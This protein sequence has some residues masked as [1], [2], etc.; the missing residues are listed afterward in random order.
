[1]LLPAGDQEEEGEDDEEREAADRR[2]DDDKHLPLVGRQIWR[3]RWGRV[4]TDRQGDDGKRG[5]SE[6]KRRGN[7]M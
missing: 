5:A 4:R 7:E 3:C 2:R 1:M 6:T